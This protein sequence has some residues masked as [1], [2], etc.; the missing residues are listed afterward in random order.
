MSAFSPEFPETIAFG[1]GGTMTFLRNKSYL[2]LNQFSGE[3]DA[4]YVPPHWHETH[5]EVFRVVKGRIEVR[6]NANIKIC[7][8]EDGDVVIRKGVVVTLIG[9]YLA[10]LLGYKRDHTL[11]EKEE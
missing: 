9:G 8:P 3:A 1:K 4:L 10:P 6:R 5:D 7:T 11:L 2:V